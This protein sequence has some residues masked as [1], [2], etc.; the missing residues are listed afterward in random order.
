MICTFR[1]TFNT[2]IKSRKSRLTGHLLRIE[3]GGNASKMLT[4]KPMENRFL[5]GPNHIWD[6]SELDGMNPMKYSLQRVNWRAFLNAVLDLRVQLNREL[7][8]QIKTH[9]TPS[10]YLS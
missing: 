8:N 7:V 4:H 1:L 2:A 6:I 5:R 10:K 9:F 3:D